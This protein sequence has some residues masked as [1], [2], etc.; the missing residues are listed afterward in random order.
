MLSAECDDG[1]AAAAVQVRPA[2]T[3]VLVYICIYVLYIRV[4]LK[5]TSNFS[6]MHVSYFPKILMRALRVIF[7]RTRAMY[8]QWLLF[9][10]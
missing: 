1:G 4:R 9:S 2:S 7:K 6:T 5:I 10:V 8:N 3:S